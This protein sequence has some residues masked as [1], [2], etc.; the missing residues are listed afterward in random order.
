MYVLEFNMHFMQSNKLLYV[1]A[2]GIHRLEYRNINLMLTKYQL[3]CK[4]CHIMNQSKE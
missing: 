2:E 1:F 3:H 4:K